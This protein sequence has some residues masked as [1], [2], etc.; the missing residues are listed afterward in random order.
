MN[1]Q[2]SGVMSVVWCLVSGVRFAI[3]R[4]MPDIDLEKTLVGVGLD[5]PDVGWDVMPIDMVVA[6]SC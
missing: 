2:L 5:I 3:P 1:N 4:E 6:L